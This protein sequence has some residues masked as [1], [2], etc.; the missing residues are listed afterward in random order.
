MDQVAVYYFKRGGTEEERLREGLRKAG[1][2]I[3]PEVVE[4]S[5]EGITLIK[6]ADGAV[7]R[8]YEAA[9]EHCRSHGKKSIIMHS[10]T[11]SYVFSCR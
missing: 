9:K 5:S 1:F 4:A 10:A 3:P 6:P 7:A 11:A 2:D 8:V